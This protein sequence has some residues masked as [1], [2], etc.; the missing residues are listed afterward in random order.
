LHCQSWYHIFCFLIFC[1]F[2]GALPCCCLITFFLVLVVQSVNKK[3]LHIAY[4]TK[5]FQTHFFLPN[6]LQHLY[7]RWKKLKYVK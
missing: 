4:K 3:R 2:F 5:H 1:L 7:S 6:F